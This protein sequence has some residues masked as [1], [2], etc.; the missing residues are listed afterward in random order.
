MTTITTLFLFPITFKRPT[1]PVGLAE[2]AGSLATVST[3][4]MMS[5]S[6]QLCGN[7][8]LLLPAPNL[9][10]STMWA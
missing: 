4:A 6:D 9:W 10:L 5:A 7:S 1:A 2:E 8:D 3:A